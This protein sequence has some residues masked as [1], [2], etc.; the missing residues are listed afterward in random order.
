MTEVTKLTK[1]KDVL[2]YLVEKFPQSFSLEGEPKP[3]KI[4][5]FDDLATRLADDDKVSKTRLRT[6]LRHYTNSWRYLRAVKAGTPRIDLDGNA[7]GTVEAEHQQHAEE[8]LAQSKSVAAEHAAKK[9]QEEAASKKTETPPTTKPAPR[10]TRK[11]PPKRGAGPAKAARQPKAAKPEL[12]P[13]TANELKVGQK[14]HAKVGNSFISGEI[15]ESDRNDVQVQLQNG[16]TVK[17]NTEA[18]FIAKQE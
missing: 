18:V 3:L 1:N 16:L 12:E 15:V 7:A 9:K 14:V 2:A 4:G 6:A 10:K 13:A 8:T 5:I 17:V 11:Q